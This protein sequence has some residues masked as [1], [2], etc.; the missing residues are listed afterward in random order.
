VSWP[1]TAENPTAKTDTTICHNRQKK[2]PQETQLQKLKKTPPNQTADLKKPT[3][4]VSEE[5]G[6]GIVRDRHQ[7]LQRLGLLPDPQLF[8]VH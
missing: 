7:Q 6:L 3:T 4:S 8:R 5:S 2:H 1:Y